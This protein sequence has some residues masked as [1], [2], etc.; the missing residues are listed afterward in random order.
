MPRS[1]EEIKTILSTPPAQFSEG[2]A[3]LL[4]NYQPKEAVPYFM[5]VTKL[6]LLWLKDQGVIPKATNPIRHQC[7]GY[8]GYFETAYLLH[9]QNRNTL[10]LQGNQDCYNSKTQQSNFLGLIKSWNEGSLYKTKFAP[11]FTK[12]MTEENFARN[13][14]ASKRAIEAEQQRIEERFK[15]MHV[16]PLDEVEEATEINPLI[17]NEEAKAI[18][19]RIEPRLARLTSKQKVFQQKIAQWKEQR[20]AE[21]V[22]GPSLP[23]AKKARTS[24]FSDEAESTSMFKL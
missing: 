7:D 9:G 19:E 1:I 13:Y 17:T 23:K 24:N 8:L 4:I 2:L 20:A 6:H 11:Y 16:V 22:A 3:T 18:A 14:L 21:Q 5:A 15:A 10:D 12:E